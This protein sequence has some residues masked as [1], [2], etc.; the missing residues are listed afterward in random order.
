MAFKSLSQ[1]RQRLADQVYQ[2]I[3]DAIRAGA[4]SSS[5]RIVQEKLAEQFEISRTPV[6]EALFR[7]EQEGILEVAGRGGFRIRQLGAGEISELYGVRRAIEGH[8][9]RLVAERRDP[10]ICASLREAITAAEA[11]D[12]ESV[13]AYFMANLSI[14]RAIV[15][16][17][18]NRYLLDFF[19]N[20]WNRGS[21]F[22]LF[23]T[24]ESVDLEKSL[25]DHMALIDVIE[26][27]DGVAASE[28]MIAHIDDGFDLQTRSR[29][30][31][32]LDR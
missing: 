12:T 14:H 24:I 11:L 28:K 31:S 26:T 32:T 22:T 27:G 1:P 17:A 20:I 23:A 5:D 30:L 8:A 21:S 10:R 2:Q 7:M 16:A 15:E 13:A 3:M 18:Q 4:I 25:G 6:R 29:R 9:A 19:D